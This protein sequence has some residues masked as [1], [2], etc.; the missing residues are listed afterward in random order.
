MKIYAKKDV[1]TGLMGKGSRAKEEERTG[2]GLRLNEGYGKLSKE[3]N[4]KLE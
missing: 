1:E 2:H 4:I 3:F